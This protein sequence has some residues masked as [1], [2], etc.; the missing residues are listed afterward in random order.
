MLEYIVFFFTKEY[1]Q[2]LV[3]KKN[4]LNTCGPSINYVDM[5]KTACYFRL[6][7]VHVGSFHPQKI[8]IVSKNSGKQMLNTNILYRLKSHLW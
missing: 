1:I 4:N 8:E 7:S 6:F 3:D 5:G 2:S